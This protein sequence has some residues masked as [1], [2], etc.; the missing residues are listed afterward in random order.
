VS[1]ERSA[2]R[3]IVSDAD[4][5]TVRPGQPI[6]YHAMEPEPKKPLLE[7]AADRGAWITVVAFMRIFK[8]PDGRAL[9]TQINETDDGQY[10]IT[11]VETDLNARKADD[12]FDDHG[13]KMLGKFATLEAAKRV[14]EKFAARWA[15]SG[16]SVEACACEEIPV[17]KRR[18]R[19]S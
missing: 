2:P 6:G 3:Y 19:T 15:K 5:R 18:R 10:G 13:H 8:R 14:C 9:A 11:A 1:N 16:K 17:T 12:V 7:V 4:A